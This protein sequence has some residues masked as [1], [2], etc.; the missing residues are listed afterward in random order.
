M[1]V[2]CPK[3]LADEIVR[4]DVCDGDTLTCG[5]CDEEFSVADL[6]RLVD[7]WAKLLPWLESHPARTEETAAV[8]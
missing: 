1:K 4:L 7:S 8:T 5:G 6:R 3:C 2:I